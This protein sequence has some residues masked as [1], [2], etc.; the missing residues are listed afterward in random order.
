MSVS[1]LARVFGPTVVGYSTTDPEPLQMI[2]ETRK[3]QKV[4]PCDPL[5]VKVQTRGDSTIK[6]G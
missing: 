4:G 2:E 1:N 6:I 3:Q 5:N